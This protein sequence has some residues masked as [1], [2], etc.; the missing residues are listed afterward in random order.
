MAVP[1]KIVDAKN[2][3][4]KLEK[5][6]ELT[7]TKQEIA[8]APAVKT[9]IARNATAS[10]IKEL[11]SG[12]PDRMKLVRIIDSTVRQFDIRDVNSPVV[13]PEIRP[14]DVNSMAFHRS[15]SSCPELSEAVAGAAAAPVGR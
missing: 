1:P 4:R 13:L 11:E 6:L 15:G 14:Q 12:N 5:Y 2:T 10:L 3:V 9:L 8:F 7:N